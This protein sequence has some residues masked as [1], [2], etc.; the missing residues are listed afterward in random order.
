VGTGPRL[1][2]HKWAPPAKRRGHCGASRCERQQSPGELG[3]RPQ[4]R[5]C[6]GAIFLLLTLLSSPTTALAVGSAQ[7]V[8]TSVAGM[9]A[10]HTRGADAVGRM[11]VT[12]R[13][14]RNEQLQTTL[15]GETDRTGHYQF[16]GLSTNP[17]YQYLPVLQYQGVTYTG[18]AVRLADAKSDAA[19]D[20]IAVFETTA[21]D[22]GLRYENAT[23]VLGSVEQAAQHL[24]FLELLTLNNPSDR[25]Y[26]PAAP[27]Q[28]MA[29]GLLRFSLPAGV[30]DIGV[31]NGLDS[32]QLID[33]DGGLASVAPIAPGLHTIS[34]SFAVPY[35]SSDFSFAWNV[36]YPS[37]SVHVLEPTGGPPLTAGSLSGA[38]DLALQ[39]HNFRVLSTGA[40]GANTIIPIVLSTLPER[41]PMQTL[42]AALPN[43]KVVPVAALS[44]AALA[45]L[46]PVIYLLRRRRLREPFPEQS[47]E[48]LLDEI[49]AL[50]EAHERGDLEEEA[51]EEQRGAL[52]ALLARRMTGLRS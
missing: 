45:A 7:T 5:P 11:V 46:A 8:P 16:N 35:H 47:E 44:I 12:L 10:N 30:D 26:V 40:V 25:T 39:G 21:Q 50:D 52:K 1:R 20:D 15:Q 13:V 42:Q 38:P 37:A 4:S 24:S 23:L 51:Y 19:Q 49:A 48:G 6:L 14:Y 36:I 32:S 31:Q 9:V 17:A 2:A 27:T 41:T 22:P 29:T 43:G 34:F 28:G 33:V 3:R 18:A